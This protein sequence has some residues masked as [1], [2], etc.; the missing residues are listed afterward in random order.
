[1]P[2]TTLELR[3][4]LIVTLNFSADVE[5]QGASHGK[6]RLRGVTLLQSSMAQ[7]WATLHMASARFSGSGSACAAASWRSNS[8]CRTAFPHAPRADSAGR[9]GAE[10]DDAQAVNTSTSKTPLVAPTSRNMKSARI[11]GRLTSE[12]RGGG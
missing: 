8:S 9:G 7:S 2:A 1:M 3:T 6:S 5:S 4:S 12:L 10:G 11:A